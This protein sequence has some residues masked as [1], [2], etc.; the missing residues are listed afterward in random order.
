[1]GVRQRGD[2]WQAQVRVKENGLI[3]YQDSKTFKGPK[4]ERLARDWQERTEKRIKREGVAGA[5]M[6][7]TTLG[8]LLRKY[9]ET[10]NAFKP[11]RRS[12]AHELEQ[13]AVDFDK[14]PL[15]DLTAH[16]LTQFATRRAAAGAGPT[17][18]LHNL[19]TVRSVLNSAKPMFGFDVEGNAASEAI[20]A[21]SRMGA[22]AKSN[23]RDRRPTPAELQRLTDE[24]KRIAA[25]PST[26]IPMATVIALAVALP[27]RLSELT[28]MRWLDL[29]DNVITLRDTKNPTKPRTEQVPVPAEAA[30]IIAG[31]P[32]IDECILPYNSESISAAFQRACERLRIVDLHFH[33]LRHEGISRLFEAGLDI[34]DV[35]MI[36]GHLSWNMLKRY[37]HLKP[38]AVLDKLNALRPAD[39]HERVAMT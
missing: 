32:V 9:G 37:T 25:S 29:K 1:M 23:S 22:V 28:S 35:A 11:L 15:A 20:A 6:S 13:L 7:T 8:D 14:V 12:M 5:K 34:P 4:A 24:F 17:T 18:I 21:L 2:S 3:V 31:L 33:D 30:V 16:T 26:I 38:K 39:T 10:R 19:A 36:S 27:R